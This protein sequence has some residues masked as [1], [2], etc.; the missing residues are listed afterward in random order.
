MKN[1]SP[2]PCSSSIDSNYCIKCG[3]QCS[4]CNIH[5][6]KHRHIFCTHSDKDC[7]D[8]SR[9]MNPEKDDFHDEGKHTCYKCG[10]QF[11]DFHMNHSHSSYTVYTCS[12]TGC[13]NEVRNKGDRCSSHGKRTITYGSRGQILYDGR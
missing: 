1:I 6:K 3:S 9:I 7:K 4:F 5:I 2:I 8:N 11:C 13:R 10:Y 12:Y